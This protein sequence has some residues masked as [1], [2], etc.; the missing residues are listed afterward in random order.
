MSEVNTKKGRKPYGV[1]AVNN[2]YKNSLEIV[3]KEYSTTISDLEKEIKRTGEKI[4][5]KISEAVK[6][7][8]ERITG[9]EAVVCDNYIGRK[10]GDRIYISVRVDADLKETKATKEIYSLFREKKKCEEICRE[11]RRDLLRWK[12]KACEAILQKK[13]VPPPPNIDGMLE[14]LASAGKKKRG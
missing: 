11:Y 12:V 10:Y 13:E 8:V 6:K 3:N 4:R 14:V 7:T 9:T 1:S 5:K 2:I